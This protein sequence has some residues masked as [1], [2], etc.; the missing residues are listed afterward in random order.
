M[1]NITA[2]VSR[3][4]FGKNANPRIVDAKKGLVVLNPTPGKPFEYAALHKA[5]KRA[6]YGIK[7]VQLTA[8][9]VVE[10]RPDPKDSSRKFPVLNVQDTGNV[11]LLRAAEGTSFVFPQAGTKVT[12]EG[13]L[14][15][16]KKGAPDV[17]VIESCRPVKPAPAAKD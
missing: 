5:Y 11:F 8:T 13:V 15:S 6:S 10:E 17:L 9:G 16:G 3:L 2:A 12:V 4:P 1:R 14:A 7:E